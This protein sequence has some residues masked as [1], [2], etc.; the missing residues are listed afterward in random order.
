M[1]ESTL[2]EL[3]AVAE[4]RGA[5]YRTLAS[6]YF[7]ELDQ[8]GIDRLAGADLAAVDWDEPLMGEGYADIAAYLAHRDHGTRQELA[9]DFAGAILGA[10]SYEERRATPYE[11]VFTSESGLLMQEARDDVYRMLCEAHLEVEEG[12]RTP[13]DHLSFECEYMA[14]QAER[15]A[16]ALAQ[17]DVEHAAR[18]LD[19]QHAFHAAHLLNWIDAYCDCL[20][21]CARTRFYRGVSKVTRGFIRADEGL[22]AETAAVLG[23]GDSVKGV[24]RCETRSVG[25]RAVAAGVYGSTAAAV[26]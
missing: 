23:V 15:L 8:E 6:L 12:L 11:S 18:V 5:F 20:D 7:K 3:R 1:D 22:M 9:S 21:G 17:G 24:A 14:V 10:G 2:E 16:T 19:A 25:S 26:C 13:E 4:A